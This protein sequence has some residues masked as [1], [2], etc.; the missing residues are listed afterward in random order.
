M[1]GWLQAK[2]ILVK[3]KVACGKNTQWISQE[4]LRSQTILKKLAKSDYESK[5]YSKCIS[6]Q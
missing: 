5:K 1:S 4:W 3:P 6:Q 2:R